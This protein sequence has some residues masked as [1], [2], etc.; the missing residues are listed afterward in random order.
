MNRLFAIL[1]LFTAINGHTQNKSLNGLRVG[2]WTLKEDFG[3]GIITET[4][5][6]KIVSLNKY[7]IIR[8]FDETTFKV[9]YK[10]SEPLLFFYGPRQGNISVKDGEWTGFDSKGILYRLE[11]WE[12]GIL[13]WR[14]EFDSKGNLKEYNIDDLEN[15]TSFYY[16]YVDGQLFKKAW[17]PPEDKNNQTEVFYP[18]NDLSISDG[19]L[20]FRTNFL[21]KKPDTQVISLT[22]K[23]PLQISSIVTKQGSLSITNDNKKLSFPLMLSSGQRLRLKL[24]SQPASS[25]YIENDTIFVISSDTKTPYKIYCYSFASH[26]TVKNVEILKKLELSRTKDRYLI[27]PPL[28]TVTDATIKAPSGGYRFYNVEGITRIDLMDYTPGKYTLD[29]SSCNT[30]G[31]IALTI[32]E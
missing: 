18:E 26:I 21:E 7:D 5:E 4:G 27:I 25:N 8:K 13:R 32:T 24:T 29:V 28:G 6:Y 20:L 3:R 31:I 9:K 10:G 30:G 1:I 14:K 22:S 15:D 11:N 23:M 19:E 12:E 16:T 17:Y 2:E